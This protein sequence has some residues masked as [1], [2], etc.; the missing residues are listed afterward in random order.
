MPFSWRRRGQT[1]LELIAAITLLAVTLTP[2][3]R[4]LR[5]ALEQDRRIETLELVTGRT[6]GVDRRELDRRHDHGG[7]RL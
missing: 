5:D 1:L 2:A 6:Y 4:I 7:L 3:L